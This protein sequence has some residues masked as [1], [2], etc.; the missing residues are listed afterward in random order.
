MS[1]ETRAFLL[2]D[3]HLVVYVNHCVFSIWVWMIDGAGRFTGK[4][5][6]TGLS[7]LR[8]GIRLTSLFTGCTI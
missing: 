3:S 5:D 2:L 4:T 1:H 8:K 7:L 6:Y